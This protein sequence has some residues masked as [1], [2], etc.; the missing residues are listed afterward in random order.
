MQALQDT[1]SYRVRENIGEMQHNA[2]ERMV[3]IIR[4][5]GIFFGAITFLGLRN[6][7]GS[8]PALT[9]G[10][11]VAI[12]LSQKLIKYLNDAILAET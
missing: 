7:L 11:G 6:P 10:T 1:F 5:T 8:L 2:P 12:E 9:I 4:I 3:L